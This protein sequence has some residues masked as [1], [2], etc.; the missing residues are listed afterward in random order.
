MTFSSSIERDFLFDHSISPFK[1]AA[2]T[3]RWDTC[4]AQSQCG[5]H[6]QCP[7]RKFDCLHDMHRQVDMMTM[8]VSNT[9]RAINDDIVMQGENDQEIRPIS[10]KYALAF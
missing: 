2:N 6:V 9:T 1:E 3:A 10:E 4:D 7:A 8:N 5:D